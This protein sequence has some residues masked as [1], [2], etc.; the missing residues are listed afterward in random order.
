MWLRGEINL[1][2]SGNSIDKFLLKDTVVAT[3]KTVFYIVCVKSP[4]A[5]K[6][7]ETV[8][9]HHVC[10]ASGSSSHISLK[11]NVFFYI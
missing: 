7:A 11:V 10:F 8:V 3:N 2:L 6:A 1:A 4:Q 5:S 9:V